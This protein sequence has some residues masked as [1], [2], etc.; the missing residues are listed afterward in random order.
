MRRTDPRSPETN[1][2]KEREME[3]KRAPSSSG[4]GGLYRVRHPHLLCYKVGHECHNTSP[5]PSPHYENDADCF[6]AY[7]SSYIRVSRTVEW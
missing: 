2:E 7:W 4:G 3:E 1:G 6:V 5:L